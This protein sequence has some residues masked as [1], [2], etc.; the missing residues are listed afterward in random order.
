MKDEVNSPE[1]Y[2][3]GGIECID[4]IE[5]ALTPEE[6]RGYLKGNIMKYV[7]RERKKGGA[8]SIAKAKWYLNRLLTHKVKHESP[9]AL[10]VR[11]DELD[12]FDHVE[13]YHF[14]QE[15]A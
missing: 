12:A 6:F 11:G 13:A 3:S 1:H 15:R 14:W 8:Q 5:A 2:T 7:W 9:P 10:N 4:A